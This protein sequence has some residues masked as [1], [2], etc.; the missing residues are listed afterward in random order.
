MK[1]YI[2][3][4]IM[5]LA[6]GFAACEDDDTL[7]IPVTNPELP[8][9]EA[10]N[11]VVN[12]APDM[13]SVISL[14]AYD[15]EDRLV[16]VAAVSA[17]TDWP[18]GYDFGSMIQV[19][20]DEDFADPIEI[21]ATT[22]DGVIYFDPE[23]LQTVIHDNYTKDPSEISVWVRFGI[24]AVQDSQTIR[25]GGADV[26]YGARQINVLPFP[27][28]KVFEQSYYLIWSADAE[29]WS[30]ADAL[31]FTRGEASVYDDPSF[32]L[33]CNFTSE[34]LGDGLYWKIIPASTYDG[35]DIVAGTTIGVVEQ[36]SE[37]RSGSLDESDAQLAGYLDLSGP[38]QFK[39]NVE[40]LTFEYIQAI[41]NFWLAGDNVNGLSWTFS[42]E[43]N[44]WTDNYVDYVGFAVLGSEFKFSPVSG[45]CGDFGS[46]GGLTFST[47]ESGV[48]T[49]AGSATGSANINVAEPGLYYIQL[50]YGTRD[51]VITKIST[52]GVI[53]GFNG[54]GE[55]VAMTSSEDGLVWTV[56]QAMTEGDEWKF[57]ANDGWDISLGGEFDNLWPFNGANFK[58]GATG[59]YDIT[60]DLRSIPWTASVVKK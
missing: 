48:L 55:S 20:R 51:L 6:V 42:A 40:A 3:L 49:G 52:F 33:I 13:P 41:P 4:P 10:G 36:D 15:E 24:T 29:T 32:S 19:S 28:A 57:R 5:A 31:P 45:W 47:S 43:P 35:G 21:P 59:T 17:T 16:P 18:E 23:D 46:D 9:F 50:N 7:G 26:F 12:A 14:E 38:V 37:S 60:L 56:T 2:F 11:V 27:P 34:Q 22:V 53:G 58:C 1:K 25:I 30:T 54:W 8:P 39:I 44:L